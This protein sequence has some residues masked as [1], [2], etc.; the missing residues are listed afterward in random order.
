DSSVQ[1]EVDYDTKDPLHLRWTFAVGQLP[2]LD[3]NYEERGPRDYLGIGFHYPEAKIKGMRWMGQG[4]YR[5]WKNRLQGMNM[6]VWQKDYNNTVTGESWD[7]PE[8]KGWHGNLYW[9]RV[10]NTESDF[11]IYSG[12]DHLFLQML[13]PQP[14]AG[15]YNNNTS[16]PFPSYDI[17]FMHAISPI[18]TKFQ[19]ASLMGPSSQQNMLINKAPLEGKLWFDFSEGKK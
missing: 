17:G 6:G 11:T 12:T 16:P 13:K 9:V 3:Y 2:M 4:P 7:Y 10:E 8:F 14:P 18:G 1:I 15:A 19:A 5:V